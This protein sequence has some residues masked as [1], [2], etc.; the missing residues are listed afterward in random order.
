MGVSVL[1]AV[2]A[3][4]TLYPSCS[5]VTTSSIGSSVSAAGSLGSVWVSGCGVGC[6]SGV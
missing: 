2:E 5:P 1:V 6:T 3:L 4:G